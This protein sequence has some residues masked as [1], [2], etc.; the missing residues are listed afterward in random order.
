MKIQTA[1]RRKLSETILDKLKRRIV[2]G[3]LKPG[4]EMASERELML[5]YGVGRPVIREAMQAL[6]AMGLVSIS[7]GERAKVIELT[8]Q[9][10]LAQVDQ[11]AHVMLSRS[12]DAL[13]HLKGA[14]IFFER[15]MVREAAAKASTSEI[16]DLRNTL[17]RQRELLGKAEPFIA[18][19]MRFHTQIAMISGNPIF[20]SVS[21]S[22][23]GWLKVYHNDML[24]W[25][26]K[27]KFTLAEHE[28]ILARIAA[29]DA[30]GAE[31]AVIRHLERSSALYKLA[32]GPKS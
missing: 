28:E 31:A 11:T 32:N 22:M 19:D 8:A 20:V 5:Q 30:D 21:E 25:T 4:D 2:Q 27:E 12:S 3:K 7:H 23:L 24:I 6:S 15:G 26:G 14:R 1:P 18:A 13:E 10:V 9:S 17:D 16:A 29:H